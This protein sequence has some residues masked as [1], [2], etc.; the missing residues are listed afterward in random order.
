MSEHENYVLMRR[1]YFYRPNAQGYT[2]KID[3]AWRIPLWTAQKHAFSND[4]EPVTVHHVSEFAAAPS[5][6]QEPTK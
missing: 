1:G 4:P 2:A 3:E 5:P 6:A